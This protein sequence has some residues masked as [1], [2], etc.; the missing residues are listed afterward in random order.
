MTGW[1]D[2]RIGKER[3]M[4]MIKNARQGSFQKVWDTVL[5]D[6]EKGDRF[7]NKVTPI[8]KTNY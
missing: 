6:Y 7:G 2:F 8:V 5:S 4:Q 1:L 3:M